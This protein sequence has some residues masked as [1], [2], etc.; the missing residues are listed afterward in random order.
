MAGNARHFPDFFPLLHRFFDE[1]WPARLT[2]TEAMVWLAMLRHANVKG[3]AW[4]SARL[5]ASYL[6]QRSVVRIHAA[7]SALVRAGLL[8]IATPGGGAHRSTVFRVHLP[9]TAIAE[10]ATVAEA[11]TVNGSAMATIAS[12]EANHCEIALEPLPNLQPKGTREDQR[13]DQREGGAPDPHSYFASLAGEQASA[14]EAWR[15]WVHFRKTQSNRGALS[16]AQQAAQ[17]NTLAGADD[18]S[19]AARAI[20]AAISGNKDQPY[21]D[22]TRSK[23]NGRND[24]KR[25]EYAEP[26]NRHLIPGYRE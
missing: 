4:P 9:S 6:G 5:L 18:A 14:V 25:R 13:E 22:S 1:A 19:H 10:T 8:T 23:P 7:K 2:P 15:E 26:N 21:L 16:P 3:L 24:R 12:S 17:L 20:R 11:A